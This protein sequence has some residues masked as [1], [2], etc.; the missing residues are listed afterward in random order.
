VTY[1]ALHVELHLY[2]YN[3]GTYTILEKYL[4]SVKDIE[5]TYNIKGGKGGSQ[6]RDTSQDIFFWLVS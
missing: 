4:D 6:L 3:R 2:R 5:S 1:V